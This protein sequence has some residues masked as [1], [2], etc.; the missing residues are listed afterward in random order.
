MAGIPDSD[1]EPEEETA[2][3]SES[4][5][6]NPQ[7][8][9]R[10][11]A[12]DDNSDLVSISSLDPNLSWKETVHSNHLSNSDLSATVKRLTLTGVEIHD[13]ELGQGGTGIVY[14]ADYNGIPCAAKRVQ[15]IRLRFLHTGGNRYFLRECLLHSKLKHK[16]IVKM[17]GVS[18][19]ATD[20]SSLNPFL[21]MELMKYTLAQLINELFIPMYV[22]LSILQDV[23][24]GLNYLHSHDIV[25]C[26]I[27]PVNILLTADLVAKIG[28]FGAAEN[29]VRLH[30]TSSGWRSWGG[31]T[32]T[33]D[34]V[35]NFGKVACN[36]ITQ[37][38]HQSRHQF[39]AWFLKPPAM[40]I[41]RTIMRIKLLK[42]RHIVE[43]SFDPFSPP[44]R[45]GLL[46]FLDDFSDNTVYKI[47]EGSIRK[48]IV[49]CLNCESVLRPTISVVHETIIDIKKG[50]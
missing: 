11:R 24:A 46:N 32:S 6:N 45:S 20:Q 19:D 25:H 7:H 48:L 28:D 22:K 47:S 39:S 49:S 26:N 4:N 50:N 14:E 41:S 9:S 8:I 43:G 31:I 30:A 3:L 13:K 15:P 10:S 37:S 1:H 42:P 16:N 5:S 35:A 36:L 44:G 18:Y 12:A 23:S 17:L 34:D 2:V 33:S 21:V 29:K 40:N 38:Q 27:D